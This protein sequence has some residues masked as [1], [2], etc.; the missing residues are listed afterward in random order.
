MYCDRRKIF[1]TIVNILSIF[2]Y[3]NQ[4]SA[5]LT[6]KRDDFVNTVNR[7]W[8]RWYHDGP[9][10]PFP[11]VRNGYVLFSLVNPPST[12]DPYCDAALWDGYPYPG[13]PYGSCEIILRAKTLN[14]HRYGSR[15]WGLWYTE[16]Y[17]N[18]QRQIWF[19]EE[20]DDPL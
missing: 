14:L 5:Q 20:F 3:V 7:G 4:S 15:G 17:P 18:L 19:M 13:G 2:I 1:L 9:S 10:T 8:W 16:S 6:L 11:S 12:W